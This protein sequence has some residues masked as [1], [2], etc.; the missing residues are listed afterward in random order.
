[1]GENNTGA[2]PNTYVNVPIFSLDSGITFE[3]EG[4]LFNSGYVQTLEPRAFYVYVPYR[5]Q[6]LL[7]N[8]D[9]ALADFNFTQLFSENRFVGNDRI[10]DANALTLAVTSRLLEQDN[11]ME[12][13]RATI[14]ERISFRS[15]QVNLVTPAATSNKSDILLALE[16]HITRHLAL[17]SDFQFDPNESHTQQYN[18]AANY[19]PEAGK[20]L[21]M[22]YRFTRGALRQYDVSTQWPLVGRWYA[23]GRWNYSLLDSRMIEATGGLE[24]N[25]EC[26]T[27][28]IVAQRLATAMQEFNTSIFMQLELND[29]VKVGP[30]PLLLL[31]QSIPGYT[32][33]N[34]K[35]AMQP[36]AVLR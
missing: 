33:L 14:G 23:V 19:R 26:W 15:P 20:V 30:D 35:S 16:G 32:Q 24:Y 27:L 12:H 8:F 29:F 34:D 36:A 10:G 3:R 18:V 25:Q 11:G 2:L 17:D 31:K 6:T 4:N 1:M 21:N 5:D 13:L 28:R 7:P 9:S 22:G